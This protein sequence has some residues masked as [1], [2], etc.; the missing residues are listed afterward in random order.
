MSK[1]KDL[2]RAKR[3]KILEL[4][5]DV[6]LTGKLSN[7]VKDYIESGGNIN[8]PDFAFNGEKHNLLTLLCRI[9]VFNRGNFHYR[10]SILGL[11]S[12]S[13][14]L[15]HEKTGEKV[16]YDFTV[17]IAGKKISA[18]TI[19]THYNPLSTQDAA[20]LNLCETNEKRF[21]TLLT[22]LTQ[23]EQLQ[24]VLRI[25]RDAMTDKQS[26]GHAIANHESYGHAIAE[27]LF[28]FAQTQP[29]QSR[30]LNAIFSGLDFRSQTNISTAIKAR[31]NTMLSSIPD[32]NPD[33]VR[34]R[35]ID[36]ILD[37]IRRLERAQY[38][39]IKTEVRTKTIYAS[40]LK[41]VETALAKARASQENYN[42]RLKAAQTPDEQRALI[43]SLIPDPS[44]EDIAREKEGAE[45]FIK[46]LLDRDSTE[47]QIKK[48]V[49]NLVDVNARFRYSN[50]I[51]N[52]F[53]KD[54]ELTPLQIAIALG[55]SDAVTELLKRKDIDIL[56]TSSSGKNALHFAATMPRFF[57]PQ[58]YQEGEEHRKRGFLTGYGHMCVIMKNLARHIGEHYNS[59]KIQEIL[60]EKDGQGSNVMN[61]F[62]LHH[63]TSADDFLARLRS[64]IED[65]GEKPAFYKE[66]SKFCRRAPEAVP[67]AAVGKRLSSHLVQV[68]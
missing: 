38:S 45:I 28:R 20:F 53:D 48:A 12:D 25:K 23:E 61:S 40:D 39:T 52:Y 42:S 62:N 33:N 14:S 49:S 68:H 31:L 44:K 8:S 65:K 51:E 24:E 17:K 19:L 11:I 15:H 9:A 66:F 36:K 43:L 58:D 64:E 67:Q 37:S 10:N 34:I 26:Y 5:K 55:R 6:S 22:K 63:K 21:E 32:S 41:L 18:F 7:A 4:S 54:E 47:A 27:A 59:T 29:I 60:A 50:L 30:L 35:E 3:A 46:T 1:T 2:M 13:L 56:K 57:S 16:D